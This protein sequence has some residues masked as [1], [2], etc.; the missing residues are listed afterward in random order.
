MIIPHNWEFN[1]DKEISRDEY[2]VINNFLDQYRDKDFIIADEHRADYRIVP[3]E[4]ERV[5]F[6]SNDEF[7]KSVD[8]QKRI[9]YKE[10]PYIVYLGLWRTNP[11]KDDPKC[12]TMREFYILTPGKQ[13]MLT[14]ATNK[15]YEH[16]ILYNIIDIFDE[17]KIISPEAAYS[18]RM[19]TNRPLQDFI[20][21]HEWNKIIEGINQ[22]PKLANALFIMGEPENDNRNFNVNFGTILFQLVTYRKEHES[23]LSYDDLFKLDTTIEKLRDTEL[24]KVRLRDDTGVSKMWPTNSILLDKYDTGSQMRISQQYSADNGE[25]VEEEKCL[26]KVLDRFVK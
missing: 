22:S 11:Q 5:V 16:K 9:V 1:T 24:L 8:F 19:Y 18:K 2:E 3:F 10:T 14:L 23:E 4:N 15:L 13:H 20:K 21:N 6:K 26:T 7:W 12:L 17:K 25:L